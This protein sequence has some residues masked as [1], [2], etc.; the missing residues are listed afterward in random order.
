MRYVLFML[1]CSVGFGQLPAP[2][3][4]CVPF[5]NANDRIVADV[6][7]NGYGPYP[8]L[9]DTGSQSTMIDALLANTFHLP[10]AGGVSVISAVGG[11]SRSHF[12]DATVTMAG[13][14]RVAHAVVYAFAPKPGARDRIYGIIGMDVLKHYTLTIDFDHVCLVL[15]PVLDGDGSNSARRH[16]AVS[17]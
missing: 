7:V 13:Q 10:D 8:F 15:R 16:L 14:S 1:M 3:P 17:H 9:L 2:K 6:T 4:P 12:V 11:R 5:H